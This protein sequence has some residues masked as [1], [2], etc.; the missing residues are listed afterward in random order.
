[1][2]EIAKGPKG[3]ADPDPAR[4]RPGP[5]LGPALRAVPPQG[6]T[7]EGVLRPARPAR[8][9]R[10]HLG[11][12][13][14]FLLLVVL[15]F[16]VAAWYLYAVALDQYASH[17]GFTVRKEESGSAVELLG[18]ITQLTGSDTSDS[19]ILYEF[20]R[21]QNMVSAVAEKIDLKSVYT[22]EEDPV[23]SLPA[24]ARVETLLRYWQRMVSVFYDRSSGLIEIR[25]KAFSPEDAQKIAQLVFSES[26]KMINALSDIAREDAT[27]HA[28]EELD[29]SLTR[30]KSARAA[31]T[32]FRSRT[33]IVDPLADI[34]GR[35]GLL[36]TL[37]A[38]LAAAL[39]E[40]DMLQ[41]NSRAEDPRVVQAQ[42][43][44]E[45]IEKRIAEERARFSATGVQDGKVEDDGYSELVSDYEALA[46]D[47]EFAENSY[48]SARSAYD[49]AVAEAQRKSRYLAAY[50]QPTLAETPEYPQ[51]PVL[52]A[53]IGALLLTGWAILGMVYYSLRDRR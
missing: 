7:G 48:L 51:R 41:S 26:S 21:S 11:L 50:I 28:R 19:D 14:S 47:L 52:L 8:L 16:A 42:R 34:Q 13:A 49:A 39:I 9:R 31:I 2:E 38:Q 22:R 10:R 3:A 17:V 43:R 5:A 40:L 12:I 27:R 36:N 1:M 35:M 32:A 4:P 24:D 18:G 37:Q 33:R 23:F 30:L 45:V 46:V 6:Q 15:P 53:V 20:I 29:H 44:V 25:V